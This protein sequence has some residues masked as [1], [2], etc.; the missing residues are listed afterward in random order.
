VGLAIGGEFRFL[1]AD[2]ERPP[3][4]VVMSQIAFTGVTPYLFY[5]DGD[6]AADWLLRVFGFGPAR[7]ARGDDGSWAEGEVAI[8]DGRIDISG[9][10]EGN[11]QLLIVSVDD[12]DALHAR[13]VGAGVAADDPKDEAY[14]PR[15]CHVT[16]P[17]GY[18][19]YFWQGEATYD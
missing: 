16:D 8:G 19:W 6:A 17:W 18:Q 4:D 1:Q 5:P 10:R 11:G 14:G 13:I 3:E 2:D 9:G 7:S 15:T 12:V